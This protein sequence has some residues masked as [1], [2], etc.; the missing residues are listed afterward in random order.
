MSD[1]NPLTGV[2]KLGAVRS[3]LEYNGPSIQSIFEELVGTINDLL[4]PT[5]YGP[6]TNL[7]AIPGRGG[8]AQS[9]QDIISNAYNL[10]HQQ[11]EVS[12]MQYI[13]QYYPNLSQDQLR[14]VLSQLSV[15]ALGNSQSDPLMNRVQSLADKV[16][17]RANTL[18]PENRIGDL[19]A[20]LPSEYKQRALDMWNAANRQ[21]TPEL[22]N[23][24]EN[25]YR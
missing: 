5:Q 6:P 25:A 16:G 19:I 15:A 7:P 22:L 3:G 24:L 9:T 18:H 8:S 20:Y 12:A 14:Q 21:P 11:G 1:Q 4:K 10:L 2:Q 13:G 17:V 23:F